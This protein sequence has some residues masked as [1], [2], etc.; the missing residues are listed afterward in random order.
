MLELGEVDVD[1][2]VTI[3]RDWRMSR[4]RRKFQALLKAAK[5]IRGPLSLR[6]PLSKNQSK[7]KWAKLKLKTKI[8]SGINA[9]IEEDR[10]KLYEI[11]EKALNEIALTMSNGDNV[12][13]L[14]LHLQGNRDMY[15]EENLRKR[16]RLVSHFLI[17]E[18]TAKLWQ[19]IIS[20]PH[21]IDDPREMDVETSFK[22]YDVDGS[23]KVNLKELGLI[24]ADLG[25]VIPQSVLKV[26]MKSLDSDGSGELEYDE[27]MRWW[28]SDQYVKALV[29]NG[30]ELEE[31]RE[32]I[33]IYQTFDKDGSGLIDEDE[34]RDMFKE[35]K[36]SGQM[37]K[38]MTMKNA[39]LALDPDESGTVSFNEFLVWHNSAK[40]GKNNWIAEQTIGE[41]QYTDLLL[42]ISKAMMPEYNETQ[43]RITIASD[44]EKDSGGRSQLSFPLFNKAMFEIAD[45]WCDS[46]DAR[47]YRELLLLI[48]CAITDDSYPPR[49]RSRNVI[50]AG[51]VCDKLGKKKWDNDDNKDEKKE[52]KDKIK[53]K[54]NK[55]S[56]K[57]K[58]GKK[59]KK[60]VKLI[61]DDE[62]NW[63]RAELYRAWLRRKPGC[64]LVVSPFDTQVNFV[65]TPTRLGDSKHEERQ[66]EKLQRIRKKIESRTMSRCHSVYEMNRSGNSSF[67]VNFFD[68]RRGRSIKVDRNV[69]VA[70]QDAQIQ[71]ARLQ[72]NKMGIPRKVRIPTAMGNAERLPKSPLRVNFTMPKKKN[73]FQKKKENKISSKKKIPCLRESNGKKKIQTKKSPRWTSEQNRS[74][75]KKIV[76]FELNGFG[77]DPNVATF[78]GTHQALKMGR[79]DGLKYH[80]SDRERIQNKSRERRLKLVERRKKMLLARYKQSKKN[81]SNK[82]RR[83]QSTQIELII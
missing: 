65:L 68:E 47:E 38:S 3:Q 50:V 13:D 39:L 32:L 23:G 45:M 48:Y 12:E 83:K 35:L 27:F 61:D 1:V 31:R 57:V 77:F 76:F 49:L 28:L 16:R 10:K 11:Q 14:P 43:C 8:A 36:E 72:S 4:V 26:A 55:K 67:H 53:K 17:R 70:W 34:F 64:R 78:R 30:T 20:R 22:K 80:R 7:R 75:K 73:K 71:H 52:R 82:S 44:W 69:K 62:R 5:L 59:K 79:V 81:E 51:D 54:L 33:R 56:T 21:N 58:V 18:V 15:T 19:L 63:T 24:C 25:V 40:D 29:V 42:R 60:K 9:A 37:N 46:I 66:M 41:E 74:S 2:V 6:S